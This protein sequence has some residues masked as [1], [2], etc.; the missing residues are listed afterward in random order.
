MPQIRANKIAIEY[1]TFGQ[2]DRPAVLLIMGLGMQ[3]LGWPEDFCQALANQGYYVIRFDNRDIGLSSHMDCCGKPNLMWAAMKHKLGLP[4]KPPYSLADMA[5]DAIGLMDVLGLPRAHVVGASMGGMIAQIVASKAPD[6]VISLTSIM[7]SSGAPG[8]PGPN[9]AA[10]AALLKRA[11][12]SLY[13]PQ[14]REALIDFLHQNWQVLHSPGFP[15][16]E[17]VQRERIRRSLDRAIY[18]Q[19]VVRQLM[20]VVAGPDRSALLGKLTVPS[21]VIH[22]TDDP[23]IPLACGQD[24]ASKIPGARFEEVPGMA[25]DLAPGVCALLLDRLPPHFEAAAAVQRAE[26]DALSDTTASV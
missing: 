10:Q 9:A 21:Y 23:L 4:L 13:R 18:P 24:T 1:E 20:A 3:L 8:L 6:R 14:H 26:E 7:S 17:I 22:G 12:P 25:H 11:A 5:D 15:T 19:G 2:P 16:P